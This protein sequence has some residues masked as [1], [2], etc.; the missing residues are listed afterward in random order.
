MS[1]ENRISEIKETY[2]KF[3]KYTS[4][5]RY[6]SKERVLEFSDRFLYQ[7]EGLKVEL[8]KFCNTESVFFTRI[9]NGIKIIRENLLGKLAS[10]LDMKTTSKEEEN[11][12]IVSSQFDKG[13]E[14]DW[15]IGNRIEGLRPL[16]WEICRNAQHLY[17]ERQ[18]AV[19]R[20]AEILFELVD[21]GFEVVSESLEQCDE[22]YFKNIFNESLR[23]ARTA[24][25]TFVKK[26][27]E[28]ENEAL[29][30]SFSANATKLK[31]MGIIGDQFRQNIGTHYSFLSKFV[32]GEKPEPKDMIYGIRLTY[33]NV[34]YLLKAYKEWKNKQL[35]NRPPKKD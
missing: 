19:E 27:I 21:A 28:K 12:A 32:H 8:E 18:I 14:Y 31:N 25:E 3:L 9:L 7:L 22:N 17:D 11:P 16:V 26:I 35:Q 2:L 24:L 23:E 33:E 34:V 4:K 13:E 6:L 5:A 30:R 1:I 15:K 29:T 20:K 10:K